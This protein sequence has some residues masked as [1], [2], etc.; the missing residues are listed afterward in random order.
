MARQKATAA[1][2]WESQEGSQ[3]EGEQKDSSTGTGSLGFSDE[4]SCPQQKTNNNKP[5][6]VT[7]D[8]I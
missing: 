3:E 4:A 7:S 8:Q 5:V 1:A 2:S 6:L